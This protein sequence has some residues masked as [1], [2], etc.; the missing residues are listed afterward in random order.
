MR[1]QL[2]VGVGWACPWADGG[3]GRSWLGLFED[4]PVLSMEAARQEAAYVM[5]TCLDELFAKTGLKPSEIDF[6]IVNCSLFNPTPSL[7]AMVSAAPC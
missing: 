5:G 3:V 2:S 4:P 7:S 6:L 1:A